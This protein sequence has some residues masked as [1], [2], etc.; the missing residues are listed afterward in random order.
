MGN[1]HGNYSHPT[2]VQ[3]A[4]THWITKNLKL[5]EDEY[6]KR[7]GWKL[8]EEFYKTFFNLK[9]TPWENIDEI[10][11][12]IRKKEVLKKDKKYAGKNKS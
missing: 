6:N 11:D 5:T 12:L 7:G 3:S 4:W 8:K 9:L 1:L 10:E 2:D